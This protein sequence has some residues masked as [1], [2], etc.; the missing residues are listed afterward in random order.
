MTEDVWKQ[1][2]RHYVDS[3]PFLEMKAN[4]QERLKVSDEELKKMDVEIAALDIK[5]EVVRTKMA[6][7]EAEL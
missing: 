6:A 7:V 5:R 2:Y 4:E 1:A 3:A